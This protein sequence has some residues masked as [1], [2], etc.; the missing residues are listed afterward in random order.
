MIQIDMRIPHRM[1]KSPRRQIAHVRQHMR[2]QR[3][4]RDIERHSQTH[5]AAPLIQL[6]AQHPPL[7]PAPHPTIPLR[8]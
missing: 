4:T 1:R 7:L 8:E 5:I 2:Q 6:A 3:I